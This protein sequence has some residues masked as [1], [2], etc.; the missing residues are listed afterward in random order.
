MLS[1][2][3]CVTPMNPHKGPSIDVH[4]LLSAALQPVEPVAVVSPRA[5]LLQRRTVSTVSSRRCALQ[6]PTQIV[7]VLFATLFAVVTP[8]DV[9]VVLIRRLIRE[10]ATETLR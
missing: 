7:N 9:E 3:S 10:H 4:F 6:R 8:S 2:S 5:A 1:F